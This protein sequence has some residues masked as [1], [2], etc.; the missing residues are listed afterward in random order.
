MVY[1]GRT[2][3]PLILG[4]FVG[5]IFSLSMFPYDELVSLPSCPI[6]ES[7]MSD[8][9]DSTEHW[10]VVVKKV[11]KPPNTQSQVTKVFFP[12]LIQE[13]SLFTLMLVFL[14]VFY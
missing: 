14:I 10:K 7:S 4:L 1:G 12:L 6:P 5:V 11:S 3:V 2:G 13:I 9:E 8:D